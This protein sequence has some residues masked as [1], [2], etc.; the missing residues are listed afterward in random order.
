MPMLPDNQIPKPSAGFRS[1]SEKVK[2]EK[3]QLTPDDE[4]I[5]VNNRKYVVID[6]MTFALPTNYV[7]E[8][9]EEDEHHE[10]D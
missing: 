2:V 6:G 1:D 10:Q 8:K 4:I 7:V 3:L 9:E 5:V